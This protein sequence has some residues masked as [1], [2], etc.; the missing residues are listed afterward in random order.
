MH[1]VPHKTIFNVVTT[2]YCDAQH[3]ATETAG[4]TM[5]IPYLISGLLSPLLGHLVDKIGQ[6]PKIATLASLMLIVVHVTLGLTGVTPFVPL[7][8]QGIAYSLY[9]SV[10]WPCVPLTVETRQTGTAF[11]VM[12]SLQNIGLA[13]FPI[14]I[15]AIYNY[16][17][18]RYLPKVE[19][20]FISCGVAGLVAGTAL[21][22]LDKRRGN[23]LHNPTVRELPA[24]EY[25]S[26]SDLLPSNP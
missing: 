15:G 1:I 5:S 21:I 4:R 12:T 3:E 22:N 14:I 24:E 23:N 10:L 7:I 11:G 2:D 18:N 6:R 26:S 19:F 9:A 25:L 16:N 8:G 13:V 17:G 20:F